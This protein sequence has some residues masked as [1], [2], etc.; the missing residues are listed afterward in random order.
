MDNDL[1]E[2]EKWQLIVST[3]L[4]EGLVTR[5][6][7]T[8]PNASKA[9]RNFVNPTDDIMGLITRKNLQASVQGIKSVAGRTAGEIA[10]E[11]LIQYSTTSSEAKI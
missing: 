2:A 3:G 6:F 4:I 8:V 11:D 7:G 1:T 5:A 10:E 9:W